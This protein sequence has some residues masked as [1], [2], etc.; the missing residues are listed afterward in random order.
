MKVH[1]PVNNIKQI[2]YD[3]GVGTVIYKLT[4]TNGGI[5]YVPGS[6]YHMDKTTIW[7]LSPQIYYQVYRRQGEDELDF[8]FMHLKWDQYSDEHSIRFLID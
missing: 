4:I 1:I 2:N 8:L 3:I 7:L 6:P 5:Q